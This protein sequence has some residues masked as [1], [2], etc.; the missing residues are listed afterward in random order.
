M[1]IRAGFLE[2]GTLRIGTRQFLDETDVSLGDSLE[3]GSQIEAYASIIR[4]GDHE[5]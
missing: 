5:A 1:K 2:G 4:F 3:Y